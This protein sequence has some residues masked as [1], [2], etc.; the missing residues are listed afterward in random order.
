MRNLVENGADVVFGHG[1]HWV[2]GSEVY[3]DKPIY[4]SLGNLVFDQM[5]S[6]KTREGLLVKLKFRDGKIISEEQI[7]TYINNWAQPEVVH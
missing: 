4:Y 2:Q 1:P 6:E 3:Q 5:W 7:D